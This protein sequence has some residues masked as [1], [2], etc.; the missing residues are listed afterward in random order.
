MGTEENRKETCSIGEF[1]NTIRELCTIEEFCLLYI[2]KLSYYYR[3]FFI[4]INYFSY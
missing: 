1:V 4:L 2:G 3:K